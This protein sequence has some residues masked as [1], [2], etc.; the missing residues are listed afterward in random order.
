[1]PP[2]RQRVTAP[3]L[4]NPI[5]TKRELFGR[6]ERDMGVEVKNSDLKSV[7][8][9]L[10]V[11]EK[12]GLDVPVRLLE[13]GVL[14]VAPE[15]ELGRLDV[16]ALELELGRVDVL[17]L[18]L[19]LGRVDVLALKEELGWLDV[20]VLELELGWLDVLVLEEELGWVDVLALEEELGRLLVLVLLLMLV[21]EDVLLEVVEEEGGQER[22]MI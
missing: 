19:E 3:P 4:S 20:L 5:H 13:V 22:S 9:G 18:E 1:M 10:C 8:L 7:V 15:V 12:G 6:V 14:A 21:L 2:T 16:L 11:T 17:V